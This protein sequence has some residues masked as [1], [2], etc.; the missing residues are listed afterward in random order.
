MSAQG[1][2]KERLLRTLLPLVRLLL[3][4]SQLPLLYL[5]SLTYLLRW[6]HCWFDFAPLAAEEPG[7]LPEILGGLF[8]LESFECLPLD[9]VGDAFF[10]GGGA[11]RAFIIGEIGRVR[12]RARFADVFLN[13]VRSTF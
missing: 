5:S 1:Q 13:G 4:T 6:V 3:Y 9:C 12:D 8:I 7:K 10:T 11:L 2:L